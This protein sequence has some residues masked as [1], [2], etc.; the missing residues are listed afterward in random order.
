MKL[1]ILQKGLLIVLLSVVLQIICVAAQFLLQNEVERELARYQH[2]TKIVH[3][4]EETIRDLYFTGNAVKMGREFQISEA[5]RAI[6]KMYPTTKR[7]LAELRKLIGDNKE[8]QQLVNNVEGPLLGMGDD[9]YRAKNLLREGEFEEAKTYLVKS[10]VDAKTIIPRVADNLFILLN[11]EKQI[12]EQ[13]PGIQED[14]RKKIQM[15]LVLTLILNV[16]LAIGLTA[17]FNRG[18]ASRLQVLSDNVLRLA[19]NQPL[20][21]PLKGNDELAALDEA[22]RKMTAALAEARENEQA[23]VEN[24]REVICSLGADVRFSSVNQA[25]ETL[26]GYDAAHLIGT[27]FVSIIAPADIEQTLDYFA[28]AKNSEL[29]KPLENRLVCK[30]GSYRNF[31]WSVRWSD[32]K[33]SYFCVAHDVT[34]AKRIER[35]KQEFVAMISHDL[36]SP[37]ASIQAFH[38]CLDRGVYGA[39]S[40]DGAQSLHSVDA[41]ITRLLNL[42][43]DLLDVEKLEAGVMSLNISPIELS[44]VFEQSL[45]SVDELAHRKKIEIKSDCPDL[46]INADGSRLIQVLVNLLSNAI[47]FSSPGTTIEVS[48]KADK[49]QVLLEVTDHGRGIP[50]DKIETVF[51][52][53]TQVEE[54]DSKNRQGSGLGLAICK[55]IVT[56]HHGNIGV[57]SQ[58]GKGSTF[59]VSLPSDV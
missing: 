11:R 10:S 52:R 32:E 41:S 58:V 23:V 16:G 44:T 15:A 34:E 1:T 48:A 31:E 57:R 54:G 5:S 25:V 3:L 42:I 4:V 51:D 12:E 43:G 33:Q 7:R 28:E 47:K 50:A 59:W 20:R 13:S 55:A 26:I 8:E 22:F 36:R 6:D 37:L 21:E 30:D 38:E 14:F 40:Q 24:A 29:E 35:M 46:S 19:S 17:V 56:Q 2:S 45:F 9:I 49:E 53:F 27:R 39:L 18:L